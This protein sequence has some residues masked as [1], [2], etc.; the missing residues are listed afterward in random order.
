MLLLHYADRLNQK[1]PLTFHFSVLEKLFVHV[2]FSRLFL[3][4]SLVQ[5]TLDVVC[6]DRSDNRCYGGPSGEFRDDHDDSL[7]DH[8]IV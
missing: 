7:A 4:R 3:L 5:A 8:P 6:V 1:H 2:H